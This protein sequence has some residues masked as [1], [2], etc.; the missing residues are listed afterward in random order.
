MYIKNKIAGRLAD[1]VRSYCRKV[2]GLADSPEKIAA[3]VALGAAMDFLPIPVISIPVSYLVARLCR[4]N[5]VAAV[6]TV[7][8]LKV[9]VPFFFTL[10]ILTGNLL[11]GDPEGPAIPLNVSFPGASVL[12]KILALGFPFLVG[13][14]V[15]ATVVGVTV[16]VLLLRLLKKR[17]ARKG[18]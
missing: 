7:V 2:A 10:N 17:M 3:G 6:A 5:T 1:A 16:Y 14:A 9:A 15:N 4:I 11:T 13:S 8:F 12:D 18:A